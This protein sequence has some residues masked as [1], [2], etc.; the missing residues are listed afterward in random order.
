MI[1]GQ[2]MERSYSYNPEVHTG[3]SINGELSAHIAGSL[4]KTKERNKNYA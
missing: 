2:E 3:L 4:F 1:S